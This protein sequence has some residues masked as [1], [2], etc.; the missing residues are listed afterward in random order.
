MIAENKDLQTC[1]IGPY[2]RKA[3]KHSLEKEK[4]RQQRKIRMDL[5]REAEIR[6][7]V[8]QREKEPWRDY[9][10]LDSGPLGSVLLPSL[11]FQEALQ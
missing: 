11:W 3:K 8:V 4:K 7:L 9:Q 6:A 2:S 5:L 10:Y 1:K